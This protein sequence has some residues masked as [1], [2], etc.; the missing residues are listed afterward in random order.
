MVLKEIVNIVKEAIERDEP[1][2]RLLAAYLEEASPS[3]GNWRKI[4]AKDYPTGQAILEAGESEQTSVLF[5]TFHLPAAKHF[6]V[7]IYV[8]Q[9]LIQD[10]FR[11]GITLS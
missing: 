2:R 10:L 6:F 4:K 3:K 7:K 1:G 9:P 11:R 8:I 5:A